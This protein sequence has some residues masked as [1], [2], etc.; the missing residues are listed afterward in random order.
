M[1]ILADQNIPQASELFKELGEVS[2]FEGRSLTQED[3][4]GVDALLIRSVSKIKEPLL[5]LYSP[6]FIGTAT[7]GV[8]HIDPDYVES[9]GAHWVSA[10][11][12]NA[13]SVAEYSLASWIALGVEEQIEKLSVWGYGHVGKQVHQLFS[14]IG[15]EVV[16]YDPLLSK[17]EFSILKNE[18]ELFDTQAVSLH[19]PLTDHAVYPTREKINADWLDHLKDDVH[20]LNAGRGEVV[21]ES[22]FLK[23]YKSR[24]NTKCVIDVFHNEPNPQSEMLKVGDI[25]TPHIAG[26]S[27]TGKIRGTKMLRS[28]LCEF[29]KIEDSFNDKIAPKQL[30]A[31]STLSWHDAVLKV[32]NPIEDSQ[33]LLTNGSELEKGCFDSLRKNYP[34]RLEFSDCLVRPASS[35]DADKLEALGF[36]LE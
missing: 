12:S 21:Q 16:A 27:F 9:K 6:K 8:D 3:L 26:Y 10:P 34:K 20:F 35:G 7:A 29:L 11:G 31:E 2:L 28:S 14:A 22:D 33:R 25:V 30:I 24:A 13:R 32:Y 4:K 17:E 23:K 18:D 19:M 15:K 5:E 36:H 1:K